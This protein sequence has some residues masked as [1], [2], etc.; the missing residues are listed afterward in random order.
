METS[1]TPFIPSISVTGP[2]PNKAAALGSPL[3]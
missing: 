2:D 3:R 1:A